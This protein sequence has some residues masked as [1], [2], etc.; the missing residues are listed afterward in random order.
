M[1]GNMRLFSTDFDMQES[2]AL[3]SGAEQVLLREPDAT[4]TDTT[5]TDTEL[6]IRHAFAA[7]PRYGIE[8]LYR[9][10]FQPLCSHAVRVLYSKAIAEDLVSEVF[11]QFYVSN[12]FQ[13]IKTS[14]RAYLYKTVRNRALNYIRDECKHAQDMEHC[15]GFADADCQQ[16]DA[17]AEYEEL[18]QRLE[19]G[20]NGLPTQRRRIFLMHRFENKKYAEIAQELQLSPRTVEVQIRK[21]SHFLRNLLVDYLFTLVFVLLIF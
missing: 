14:Y 3:L 16:P 7:D 1:E 19:A 4:G 10:Y 18:Y 8:L 6:F 15:A 2:S 21:A 5:G 12:N 11:Y 13:D 9:H 20:I 17:L